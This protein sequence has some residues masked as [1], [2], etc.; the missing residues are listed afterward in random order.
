M[1]HD[2]AV[3]ALVIAVYMTFLFLLALARKDNSL[4]D[5]AW[6]P[7]F[8]LLTAASLVLR[9]ALTPRRLLLSILVL[10]WAVRLSL[11]IFRRNRGRGEDFRY[12][13]W[14]ARWGRASDAGGMRGTDHPTFC[15]GAMV[16]R[17]PSNVG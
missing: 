15:R 11:H 7:G 14:R 12:A 1:G 3:S 4:V 6:G 5:I 10:V 9:P 17:Q 2:I 13:A 8:I 16:L